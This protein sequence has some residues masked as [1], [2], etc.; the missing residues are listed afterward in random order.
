MAEK[1][2]DKT[3]DEQEKTVDDAVEPTLE[4]AAEAVAEKPKAKSRAKKKVEAVVVEAAP[5]A[6][7]TPY[8]RADGYTVGDRIEHEGFGVGTVVEVISASATSGRCQLG[9][10]GDPA[11][12]VVEF[13]SGAKTLLQNFSAP[14]PAAPAA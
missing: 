7:P 9:E 11:K 12:M 14:A 13:D 10:Y 5:P 2:S 3:A 6:E 1:K 4:A 8:E